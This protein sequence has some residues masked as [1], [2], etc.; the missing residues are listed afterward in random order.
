[1]REDITGLLKKKII[2][3]SK[4]ATVNCLSFTGKPSA[5]ESRKKC[6]SLPLIIVSNRLTAQQLGGVNHGRA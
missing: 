2:T 1:M 4:K 3:V 6:G 5:G